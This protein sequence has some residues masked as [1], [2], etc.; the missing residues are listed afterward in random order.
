MQC[1]TCQ[2]ETRR[3][4]KDRYGNQRFQC[5]PCGKT[6]SDRP[7]KPLGEMRLSMDKALLCLKRLTEGSSIRSIVRVTGVAKD[8]VLN[9]LVIVG[10]KCEEFLS[11]QLSRVAVSDVQADEIW[12]YVAMKERTAE[13]KGL[14]TEA[15][16]VGD[17]YCY[18]A[19]ER[20]TKLILSWHL[21]KRDGFNTVEFIEKVEKSTRGPFQ[22][23]TDGFRP[24]PS[25]VEVLLGPRG[26]DHAAVIKTYG[27]IDDDHRYSPS[28]VLTTDYVCCSG[29]PD[30]KKA[31]TSHVERQNLEIRMKTRRMT[32]L[33]NAFS[34]KW[35]NHRIALALYFATANF[36]TPHGTLTKENDGVKTTPA[37]AAGL[38]DHVWTLEELL[39]EATKS[40]LN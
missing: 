25:A 15:E 20:H 32:R 37:M 28:A 3:F 39:I 7:A 36:V 29:N 23:S 26:V 40:T 24:Y 14:N 18:V 31:C 13:K 4:G 8:T 38:T 6:F 35:D 21:G 11:S 9:L 17:A 34:K 33:T 5:S 2:T 12:G 10:E 19:I 22:L 1:P 27:K 16:E 30:L